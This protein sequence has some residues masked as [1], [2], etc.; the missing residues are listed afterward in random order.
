MAPFSFSLSVSFGAGDPLFLGTGPQQDQ[1]Q[2]DETYVAHTF[3]IGAFL[4]IFVAQVGLNLINGVRSGRFR[5][6]ILRREQALRENGVNGVEQDERPE[7]VEDVQ[8]GGGALGTDEADRGQPQ[9]E[10]EGAVRNEAV[11]E[12][13]TEHGQPRTEEPVQNEVGGDRE[14]SRDPG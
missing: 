8:T 4:A 3:V 2:D 9:S 6:E 14:H 5:R 1:S 13:A 10:T 12:E 11:G 7:T